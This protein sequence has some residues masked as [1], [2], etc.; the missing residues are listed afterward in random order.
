MG[1]VAEG[2]STTSSWE[3]LPEDYE[4]ENMGFTLVPVPEQGLKPMTLSNPYL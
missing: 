2:W 4:W 3:P 1:R